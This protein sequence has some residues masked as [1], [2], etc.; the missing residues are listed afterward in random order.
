ME[1][2]DCHL[3]TSMT[4][5]APAFTCLSWDWSNIRKCCVHVYKTDVHRLEDKFPVYTSTSI[6]N[7][8]LASLIPVESDKFTKD[9]I[10]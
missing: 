7:L 2:R 9:P 5:P 4:T 1:L 10:T 3:K 8:S 6:H